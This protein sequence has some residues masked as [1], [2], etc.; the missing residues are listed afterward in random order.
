MASEEDKC[1][2]K[3]CKWME[4]DCEL[5]TTASATTAQEA[6]YCKGD[7]DNIIVMAEMPK[8]CRSAVGVM[9]DGVV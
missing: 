3:G 6:S 1:L 7:K 4:T 5:T 8:A 2:S 9:Y